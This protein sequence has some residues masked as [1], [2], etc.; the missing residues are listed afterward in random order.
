MKVRPC[1]MATLLILAMNFFQAQAQVNGSGTKGKVPVWTG[2]TTLR[3]SNIEQGAGGIKVAGTGTAVSGVSSSKVSGASG[4]LEQSTAKTGVVNGSSE[5][6]R[7]IPME[8]T[9]FWDWRV[10]APRRFLACK[11]PLPARAES[12]C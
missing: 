8:Q 12:G 4:V 9:E 7:A 6:R 5:L 1:F 10:A 11:V 2:S 3:N